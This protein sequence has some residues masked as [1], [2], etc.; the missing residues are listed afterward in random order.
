VFE[1]TVDFDPGADT[2]YLTPVGGRDFFVLK[3]DASGNFVWAKRMGGIG[4][5]ESNSIT[6]DGSGN[7]YIAGTFQDTVDFDPGV[8]TSDLVSAGGGDIYIQ[9]LDVAGNLMWVKQTGGLGVDDVNSITVDA[10]EMIYITGSFMGTVDFDPG[11]GIVNLTASGDI[12]IF[13]QKLDSSGN[14]IWARQMG[15]GI[16]SE[17]QGRSITVDA[18]ENVY[19][20][21]LFTE[22]VDFDPGPNTFFLTS[23]NPNTWIDAIFIQKLD[24]SGNFIWAN[25][26]YGNTEVSVES[27]TTDASGNVYTIGWFM[28]NAYVDPSDAT[29][30]LTSTGSKD[31]FIQK[32]DPSGN[33]LWAKRIGGTEDDYPGSITKDASGNLYTTGTF[34]STVDFDPGSGT[35]NL[36]SVGTTDIFIL[37]LSP[38]IETNTTITTSACN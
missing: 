2:A 16:H 33:L 18:S 10:S 5:D 6:I 4:P 37:K 11:P 36:V 24:S 21:G 12:D 19:T 27:N 14:F 8:G 7:L 32:L 17:N 23:M 13:I 29:V 20:T 34:R 31:I 38:C 22:T 30:R 26:I 3:L 1:G 15:G 9:K 35:A 25:Q 28:G